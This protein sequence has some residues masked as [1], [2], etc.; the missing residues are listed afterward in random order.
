[1]DSMLS[2]PAPMTPLPRA[3]LSEQVVT[4]MVQMITQG[5][6]QPGHRLPPEPELCRM[7]GIGRSTLREAIRA[8]TFLGIL[9]AR[10]GEGTFVAGDTPKLMD[11]MLLGGLLRSRKEIEDLCEA[12]MV[13]E[14]ELAALAARRATEPQLEQL[15]ELASQ[16][17]SGSDLSTKEFVDLDL[18]FHLAIAASAG[19]E[20]LMHL[21]STTRGLLQEWIIRSQRVSAARNLAN[22]GHAVI[23]AAVAGKDP[24]AARQAMAEHLKGSFRLLQR[25]SSEAG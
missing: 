4:R 11:G 6:W 25:A 22:T 16:M 8:L 10:P 20:I 15:R 12:R 17:E 23:L 9:R 7:L 1:M 18:R 5:D 2:P 13:L 21:L 14:T 19:N 24:N 3:S